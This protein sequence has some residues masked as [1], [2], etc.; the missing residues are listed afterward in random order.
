M[1]KI[2]KRNTYNT[3]QMVKNSPV[4]QE[5]WFQSLSREYPPKKEMAT[6]TSMLACR[7]PQIE[8]PDG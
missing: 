8:E 7:N 3:A 2:S 5:T 1:I 6:H 4:L